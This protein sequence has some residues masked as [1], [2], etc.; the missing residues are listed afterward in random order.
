MKAPTYSVVIPTRGNLACLVTC[1]GAV[2]AKSGKDTEVIVVMNGEDDGTAAYLQDLEKREP[3]LTAIGAASIGFSSA[4]NIGLSVAHGKY[5]VVLHDDTVVSKGWLDGLRSALRTADGIV[6]GTRFGYCGPLTGTGAGRQS[7][8]EQVPQSNSPALV[9][10]VA[11]GLRTSGG[12]DFRAAGSLDSFC[13]MMTRVA[14]DAVGGFDERFDPAGFEDRDLILRGQAAGFL[15]CIA[16]RVFVYH[17]GKLTTAKHALTPFGDVPHHADFLAKWNKE[18][19]SAQQRLGFLMRVRIDTA[20]EAELFVLQLR[21]AKLLGDFAIVLNDRSK[22][23]VIRIAAEAG[24]RDFIRDYHANDSYMVDDE[25]RDRNRLLEM[26]Q[27][28]GADWLCWIEPYHVFDPKVTRRTF[29]TL[30]APPDPMAKAY[31]SPVRTYWRGTKYFR[32]DDDWGNRIE[33]ALFKNERWGGVEEW[34]RSNTLPSCLP[35]DCIPFTNRLVFLDYSYVDIERAAARGLQFSEQPHMLAPASSPTFTHLLMVKNEQDEIPRHITEALTWADDLIVVDTGSTDRTA[36]ICEELG[37]QVVQYRCCDKAEDPD[38]DL[39][40]YS[41]ARNFAIECCSTEYILFMDA[42]E[43]VA[44]DSVAM[45]PSLLLE[46]RDGF[47]VN[48]LNLQRDPKTGRQMT[49]PQIQARL[50]KNRP[51]I[52]YSY[53]VHETIEKS[54][55]DSEGKL[56][57]VKTSASIIHHGYLREKPGER[58]WKAQRYVAHLKKILETDPEEPRAL[59]AL[60]QHCNSQ[61]QYDEGDSLIAQALSHD[62]N[63]FTA[64]FDLS[65]RFMRRAFD[66]LVTCPDG[67]I[68]SEERRAQVQTLVQTLQPWAAAM[69]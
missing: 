66:L 13:I 16:P 55:H 29:E 20:A 43:S 68:P 59:Y 42:D 39:C 1:L 18:T 38:H 33:Q 23:D 45:I 40:D 67:C 28:S 64:R 63:F 65:L 56:S 14:Y 5:L 17:A 10:G 53:E 12:S 61:H 34:G 11:N 32:V 69:S 51:E 22:E 15:A 48:V 21:Q 27:S 19:G 35:S 37:V 8:A 2:L 7:L 41:K 47:I 50:F 49:Y 30:M 46:G 36:A 4:A 31:L 25:R 57:L 6:P 9:E 26:G 3:R 60:G 24:L 52:R 58:E 54:F 44:A 62:P